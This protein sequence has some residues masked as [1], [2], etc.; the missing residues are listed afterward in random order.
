MRLTL[1]FSRSL[2]SCQALEYSQVQAAECRLSSSFGRRTVS[3]SRLHGR[4]Q[5]RSRL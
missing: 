1:E 4:T 5:D 3:Q 2:E